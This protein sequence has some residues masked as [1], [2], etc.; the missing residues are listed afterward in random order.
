MLEIMSSQPIG[1][2]EFTDSP[3]PQPLSPEYR[4][5]GSRN[6][7]FFRLFGCSKTCLDTNAARGDGVGHEFP[8]LGSPQWFN[9]FCT[10]PCL[11][12]RV[13]ISELTTVGTQLDVIEVSPTVSVPL[14]CRRD[15]GKE[16]YTVRVDE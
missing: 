10:T 2:T 15:I 16:F 6:L 8:P 7:L 1:Q 4:G 5:E 3:H 14:W 9:G 13:W 12:L 11:K